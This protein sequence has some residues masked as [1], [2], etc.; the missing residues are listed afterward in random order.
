MTSNLSVAELV[1]V[2]EWRNQRGAQF[3]ILHTYLN[4]RMGS[5]SSVLLL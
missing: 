5:T 3:E 4:G 1:L 2:V